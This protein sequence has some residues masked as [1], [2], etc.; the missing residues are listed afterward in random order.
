MKHV[1]TWH[2]TFLDIYAAQC[3][4]S[5]PKMSRHNDLTAEELETWLG[6]VIS[7]GL[8][9]KKGRVPEF[10]S[11]EWLIRT[12]SYSETMSCALFLQILRYLHF[13][14]N[15][16]PDLNK[17][18]KMHKIRNFLEDLVENF[19]LAYRPFRELSLD[20]SMVKFKGRLG[21]KQY[22]AMKPIKWGI[23]LFVL[24]ESK[25]GYVLNI[26]PYCGQGTL[27]HGDDSGTDSDEE[28]SSAGGATTQTVMKLCR[29]IY[30]TGS[31]VYFDNYYTS[32]ELL[33]K[34]KKKKILACGTVRS[35]RKGLPAEY[36]KKTAP[37]VKKLKRGEALFR[38]KRANV[39]CDMEG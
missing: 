31:H 13:V 18:D 38:K 25:S 6:L 27:D 3:R 37:A 33:L 17:D 28:D 5:K 9:D 26:I 36:M 24:A 30:N 11:K 10:W 1:S 39:S 35:N 8:V 29:P 14:N 12:Q 34:L 19:R 16:V 15:R 23:K 21:I 20:E 2:L 32:P 4:E 22:I 7:M